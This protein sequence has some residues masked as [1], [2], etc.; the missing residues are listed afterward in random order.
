M[1]EFLNFHNFIVNCHARIEDEVVFPTLKEYYLRDFL[2]YAKLIEW[3]GNDHKLLEKLG[4]SII[5][6]GIRGE[7][8]NYRSRLELYFKILKDHNLREENQIFP[9]WFKD[10]S[11]NIRGICT[12]RSKKIIDRFFMEKSTR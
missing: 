12:S 6:Y 2:E 7:E 10:I 1:D 5:Q 3:V 4:D 11:E 8:E 9:N